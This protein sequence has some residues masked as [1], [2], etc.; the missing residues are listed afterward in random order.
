M[1]R[2]ERQAVARRCAT[3]ENA[4]VHRAAA[5]LLEYPDAELVA[6]APVLRDALADVRPQLA[7]P[8]LRVIDHLTSRPVTELAAE[9]V[10]T[11]DLRRRCSPYLTYFAY[12]DT[13]K[14]G[15]ALVEFK[16]AYRAAGFEVAD[17]E[18][19]DHLAVVLELAATADD[20]GRAAGI[21]LLLAHRAGLELLR[22]ALLDAGSPW[23]DVL[24]AVCATLPPLAG[25]DREAVARLAAEGP[26]EEEV[27]LD[28]FT[29]PLTAPIGARR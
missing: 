8:L 9:Y 6:L 24:V 29:P 12:G 16:Q 17:A 14:R 19:P 7:A 2:L 25:D 13:R 15:V 18:L 4:V 11:F 22:L 5:L 28:P 3:R 20:D 27:G 26:P 23:A 21:G 10:E 1:N